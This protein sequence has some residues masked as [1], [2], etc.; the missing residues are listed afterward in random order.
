[1][2]SNSSSC[3]TQGEETDRPGRTAKRKR[4]A[5]RAWAGAITLLKRPS[6][7]HRLEWAWRRP[8]SCSTSSPVPPSRVVERS[9]RVAKS[10]PATV[11]ANMAASPVAGER[12]R[13][14]RS[15][16]QTSKCATRATAWRGAASARSNEA[17]R[18]SSDRSHRSGTGGRRFRQVR[19]A[20]RWPS[21]R[22]E[23]SRREDR[24][25]PRTAHAVHSRQTLALIRS[26]KCKGEAKVR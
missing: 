18:V 23:S 19:F 9:Q 11:A 7:I 26:R 8:A 15:T 17:D 14:L 12:R 5:R 22:A 21:V 2:T 20:E 1:M 16:R 4:R 3:R 24:C 25:L 6:P 10:S 13:V